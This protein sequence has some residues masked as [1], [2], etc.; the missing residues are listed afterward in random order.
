[1]KEWQYIQCSDGEWRWVYAPPQPLLSPHNSFIMILV[2]A[3][4]VGAAI[5]ESYIGRYGIYAIEISALVFFFRRR[6]MN[7]YK[8]YIA[9]RFARR[10]Q[11]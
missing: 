11:S 2:I 8:K 5:I 3:G 6:L 7:L 9:P 4:L 10:D 1:M